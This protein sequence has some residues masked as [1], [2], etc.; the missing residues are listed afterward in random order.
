MGVFVFGG[1]IAVFGGI[2]S[3]FLYFYLLRGGVSKQEQKQNSVVIKEDD[4]VVSSEEK[5]AEKLVSALDRLKEL[6]SKLTTLQKYVEEK[7]RT[8]KK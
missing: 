1:I 5:I 2:L 3:V 4:A 6:E 8:R 7:V